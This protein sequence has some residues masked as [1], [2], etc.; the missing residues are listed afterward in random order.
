MKFAPLGL[1]ILFAF[2]GCSSSKNQALPT[3]MPVVAASQKKPVERPAIISAREWGST[4]QPIPDSRKQ[5]PQWVTIHHAGVMWEA[6]T[7]PAT[8]VKNMQGWGQRDKNWPDLPYHFL[9]APDGAIY[10]GRAL[11]YEPES[12]TK[13]PLN[14]NIGVEM[15]GNFEKQRPSPQQIESCARLT[16]WLC[17]T[18]NIGVDHIRGHKDAAQNQTDCPGRD[19]YRYLESGQFKQ[20]VTNI[21]D[22]KDPKIEPGPA[23]EG[24]PTE[25]I[26]TKPAAATRAS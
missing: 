4:P 19:F 16:A 15:M 12:N 14:G 11:I 21:L 26:P 23:L 9:I 17:E 1:A 5:T 22:G 7:P 13:Y 20:W 8:F 2:S 24:G 6:K 3:T 18:Q 10:E 25:M